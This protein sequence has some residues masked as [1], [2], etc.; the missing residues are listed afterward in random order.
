MTR[1]NA[2]DVRSVAVLAFFLGSGTAIA[3]AARDCVATATLWT[4]RSNWTIP[5]CW[6]WTQAP[7]VLADD[8]KCKCGDG[9]QTEAPCAVPICSR[10]CNMHGGMACTPSPSP[11]RPRRVCPTAVTTADCNRRREIVRV[12][13]RD[14]WEQ[15]SQVRFVG[16]DLC[17][18]GPQTTTRCGGS[19]DDGLQGLRIQVN[20]TGPSRACV[21]LQGDGAQSGVKLQFGAG[22]NDRQ[23]RI[24]AVHEF[25]HALGFKHEQA[26]P[27]TPAWCTE[28]DQGGGDADTSCESHDEWDES[29]VM[30]YCNP[31][32]AGDGTLSAADIAAV[33]RSY[34]VN[35]TP[36]CTA[37]L[38]LCGAACVNRSS[39]V[40]HCGACGNRCP[41][42]HAC[43]GSSC[44]SCDCAGR[45]AN[46]P[47]GRTCTC[48]SGTIC[49][50][51][52]NCVA[53]GAINQPCCDSN[54][55]RNNLLCRG[56]SC[57]ARPRPPPNDECKC[58]DG[59][60]PDGIKCGTA[61]CSNICTRANHGGPGC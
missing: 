16:W 18:S 3:G 54:T 4:P 28:R 26:R 11:E 41:A 52:Q 50:G 55:C 44:L 34:D 14:T 8:E 23:V 2:L 37:P 49:D 38:W 39:D 22:L 1:K 45:C 46:S 10:V 53:C 40:N 61:Q 29:S 35:S 17:S 47:C 12:A 43:I 6:E 13:V 5:V 24:I 56:G 21:G 42:D 9:M 60:T 15:N 25:G 57:K 7:V 48:A 36:V 30:N 32:W 31:T 33:R 58:A 19:L 27:D 20:A 51:T 59:W